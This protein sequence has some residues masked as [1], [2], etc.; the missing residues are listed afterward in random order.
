MI[1]GRMDKV[2]AFPLLPEQ[3]IKDYV[4]GVEKLIKNAPGESIII[5]DFLGGTTSNIA[6]VIA[7]KYNVIALSGLSIAMLIAAD[8][9]RKKY[10]GVELADKI[11]EKSIDGCKDINKILNK[12]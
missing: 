8:E 11:I 1:C 3:S 10:T 4:R 9:F 6:A 12:I 2:Y 5:S 7:N